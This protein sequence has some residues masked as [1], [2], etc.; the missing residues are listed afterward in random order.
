MAININDP[1]NTTSTLVTTSQHFL[2]AANGV[3]TADLPMCKLVI[4]SSALYADT[5]DRV[6]E[7][8]L[9]LTSRSFLQ[10][11]LTVFEKD[12]LAALP[13]R[14]NIRQNQP[15]LNSLQNRLKH[16]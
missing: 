16:I 5:L 7:R 12:F 9:I 6:V 2:S 13:P 3:Q 10:V 14:V 8:S 1:S 15:T 4:L 11:E